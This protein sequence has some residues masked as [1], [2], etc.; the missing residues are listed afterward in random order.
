MH[1]LLASHNAWDWNGPVI[2]HNISLV[3][4]FLHRVIYSDSRNENSSTLQH[5]H[6]QPSLNQGNYLQWQQQPHGTRQS[7]PQRIYSFT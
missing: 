2:E 7:V 3:S 4:L 1:T 5:Q 6:Q